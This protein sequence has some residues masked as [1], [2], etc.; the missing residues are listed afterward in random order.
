LMLIALRVHWRQRDTASFR[1]QSEAARALARL[2]RTTDK[3][4]YYDYAVALLREF[5]DTFRSHGLDAASYVLALQV[6][7]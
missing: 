4:E 6:I 7:S 5:G 1:V 3:P 2:Y